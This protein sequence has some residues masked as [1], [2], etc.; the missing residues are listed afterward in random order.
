MSCYQIFW[1]QNEHNKELEGQGWWCR[2]LLRYETHW[3]PRLHSMSISGNKNCE[4]LGSC[5]LLTSSH[6][7]EGKTSESCYG[8]N[9]LSLSKL[10]LKLNSQCNGAGRWGLMGSVR[11]GGLYPEGLTPC[12]KEFSPSLLATRDK[13]C[14]PFGRCSIQAAILETEMVP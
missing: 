5:L 13:V 3:N 11:L 10:M 2:L 12:R 6:S 1:L 8:L 4:W 14:L 9:I 7:G